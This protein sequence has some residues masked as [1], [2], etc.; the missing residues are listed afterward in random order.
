M[1]FVVAFRCGNK[2][3][4]PWQKLF[5]TMI[6]VKDNRYS[7]LFRHRSDVKGPRDGAGNGSGIITVIEVLSGVKLRSSG[8][9]LDNDGSICLAGSLE[10]CI[11][12]RWRYAVYSRDGVSCLLVRNQLTAK[13]SDFAWWW[14]QWVDIN[15]GTVNQNI[16]LHHIILLIPWINF[17]HD[18]LLTCTKK[19]PIFSVE[20]VVVAPSLLPL[21]VCRRTQNLFSNVCSMLRFEYCSKRTLSETAPQF[22][23]FR[24]I[25]LHHENHDR[26][27]YHSPLHV[28]AN[29]QQHRRTES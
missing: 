20:I 18:Q 5:G 28:Q 29:F 14:N 13:V 26:R 8:R 17:P 22:D 11:D 27:T 6:G 23:D 25:P 21:L 2:S 16:D 1:L 12:A 24:V 7:I 19:S 15:C 3:I 4:Y 10:T 9:E